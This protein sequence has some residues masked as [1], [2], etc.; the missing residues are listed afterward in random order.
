MRDPMRVYLTELERE[1]RRLPE[2][3]RIDAQ[4]EIQSH[5]ADAV[6]A[7]ASV[8]SVLDGLGSPRE[9]A[10][11]LVAEQW[12]DRTSGGDVARLVLF[13]VF[14][15]GGSL[16]TFVVVTML[17][18]LVV[19]FGLAAVA[20]PFLGLA[21]QLGATW[22]EMNLPGGP[23]PTNLSLVFGVTLAVP[24]AAVALGAYKGLRL[25]LSLVAKGFR[26]TLGWRSPSRP[27]TRIRA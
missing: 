6:A 1:L 26:L 13:A 14:V 20:S 9:L 8:E 16:T 5:V 15:A 4:R 7:G 19:G 21:R 11:G 10:R 12:V 3:E 25:Y 18:V 2:A 17:G 24:C 27:A 22:V 23:V